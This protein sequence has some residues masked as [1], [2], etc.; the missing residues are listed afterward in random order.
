MEQ[1]NFEQIKDNLINMRNH[2]LLMIEQ[3]KKN[4][5]D[6]EKLI[7]AH[8]QNDLTDEDIQKINQEQ[9][10]KAEKDNKEIDEILDNLKD[11]LRKLG[12]TEEDISKQIGK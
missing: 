2:I 11:N 1:V 5:E 4:I 9:L 12:L 7:I 3:E 10:D 8:A 6:F